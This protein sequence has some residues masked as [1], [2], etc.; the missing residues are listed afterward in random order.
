[1]DILHLK[2][3]QLSHLQVRFKGMLAYAND[4]DCF[5]ESPGA[6]WHR[7]GVARVRPAWQQVRHRLAQLRLHHHGSEPRGHTPCGEA[8]KVVSV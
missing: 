1:M 2:D 8:R 3:N 4:C 5:P 6:A 7:G